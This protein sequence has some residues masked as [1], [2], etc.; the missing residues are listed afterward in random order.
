MFMYFVRN[1]PDKGNRTSSPC[2]AETSPSLLGNS[3]AARRCLTLFLDPAVKRYREAR[4]EPEPTG[5]EFSLFVGDLAHEVTD[6]SLLDTFRSR[7][8]SAK[9]AKVG[10]RY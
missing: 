2:H 1:T 5:P 6:Y 10:H 7:Y 4:Q 8:A 9:S 3:T